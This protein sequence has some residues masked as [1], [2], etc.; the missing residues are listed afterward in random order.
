MNEE[1]KPTGKIIGINGSIVEVEFLVDKPTINDLL[2]LVDNPKV[3]MQ[4]YRSASHTSFYCITL[5]SLTEISRG[6]VVYNTGEQLQVPVGDHVLG[7]VIDIFGEA[8]DGKGDISTDNIRPIFKATPSYEEIKSNIEIL[9][10][11]IKVVDL[12]APLI[13][14]GK[15]GLFGGSGVGKTVLLTEI[16][17]NIINKDK[18]KNVSVFCGVGERTRE[19]HEL[20]LELEKREVLPYVSL[21][22][23][24]MGESPSV[25]YLTAHA[26]ASI[27]EYF[28]DEKRKNV[29]F[30]IDN[31]FRFAQAGNELSLLMN[32][33]PS[34]GGYQATLSSEMAS[35][36]ERLVTTHNSNITTIEA[37]YLPADD[38]LDQGVQAIYDYL[39]SS[40]VLSRDIYQ[41]GRFPAIDIVSS[42]SSALNPEIVSPLHY[43]VSVQAQSLLKKSDSLERIVSLVGEAEL[44]DEDRLTYQRV[45]K[46]RNYMTQ[47]FYS[48]AEQTGRPGAYVALATTVQDARDIIDGKYDDVSEDKFMYIGSA[49]ELRNQQ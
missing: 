36:H 6:S 19:G 13:A 46:L 17:H 31:M 34:E 12:F 39:N 9:E 4:V 42:G 5:G 11:G 43:Y 18:E 24:A 3:K 35:I 37:I 30:F 7:R 27:A 49:H 38:I 29:L 21:I 16:L 1:N 10:T 33:I 25:R 15:T 20:V 2:I 28:R 41:E 40:I 45:K 47:N 48:T 8:K 14:G 22:F 32:T 26:A 44:S 23:G